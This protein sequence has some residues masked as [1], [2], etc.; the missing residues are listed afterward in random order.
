M[1]DD[2]LLFLNNIT[3]HVCFDVVGKWDAYDGYVLCMQLRLDRGTVPSLA[4][5]VYSF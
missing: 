2:H 4:L 5:Q 1:I 3:I